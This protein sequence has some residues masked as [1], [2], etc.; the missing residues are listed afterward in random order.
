MYFFSE[1]DPNYRIKGSRDPLGFQTL[2]SAAGHL[3]VAHLSTVSSSLRDYMIL[4][5]GL[6]FYG[7]RP[8][9]RFLNFFLKFEQV[10]AFARRIYDLDRGFNGIDFVNKRKDDSTFSISLNSSDMLLSNQRTYGVYGKYIRPFRDMGISAD[11]DFNAVMEHSFVKTSVRDVQAIIDRLLH[12]ESIILT[13][14]QLEPVAKLIKTLTPQE[15]VL[16]RNYILKVPTENHPQNNL[17]DIVDTNRQ[18]I[19]SRF[20]LHSI[21]QILQSKNNITSELELALEN[22][23][24][25]DKVLFPLNRCFTHLLSQSSWTDKQIQED[26]FIQSLPGAVNFHFRDETMQELN[27]M[28]SLDKLV[29][30]QTLIKRNEEVSDQRGSKG[31]IMNENDTYKVI[32]GENGQKQTTLD[33][34]HDFEYLYFLNTYLGLYKQIEIDS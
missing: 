27:I 21:I 13:K 3:A 2:W 31:W 16:Y 18:I 33:F 8:E 23:S 24:N 19:E 17:F 6:Y 7:N 30:V 26:T 12:S 5:Y 10:C 1:I 28:L 9:G 20:D 4:A 15:K 22:I 29:M 34:N 25:T 11:K 14:E 32:Y